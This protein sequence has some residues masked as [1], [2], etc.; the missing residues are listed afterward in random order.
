MSDEES[1][2]GYNYN[3]HRRGGTTIDFK[4]LSPEEQAKVM[5]LPWTQW[6]NSDV[7]NRK[8]FSSHISS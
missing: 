6:M 3:A 8:L 7:K 5:R 4:S 2:D 1:V